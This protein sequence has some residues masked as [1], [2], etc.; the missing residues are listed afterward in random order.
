[1]D[2]LEL[3]GQFISLPG[4]Q[5]V[6]VGVALIIMGALA[7]AIFALRGNRSAWASAES[8]NKHAAQLAQSLI[9]LN[10]ETMHSNERHQARLLEREEEQTQALRAIE[11]I[12][13]YS[14]KQADAT[15]QAIANTGDAVGRNTQS[16][17]LLR[18]QQRENFAAFTQDFTE[19]DTELVR[20]LAAIQSQLDQMSERISGAITTEEL[21]DD[22]V[23]ILEEFKGEFR[24]KLDSIITIV[25]RVVELT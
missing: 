11:A 14:M 18:Q 23:R 19:R 24:H 13:S 15:K 7:V 22:V 5:V 6:V 9:T 10:N 16:I 1:V 2:L 12:L 8:A 4:A 25:S 21:R 3:I 17:D 20:E